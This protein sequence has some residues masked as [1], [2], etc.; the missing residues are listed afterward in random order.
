MAIDVA[1]AQRTTANGEWSQRVG[2]YTH[3]PALICQLG[4]D[5][6]AT[7]ARVGLTRTALADSD[8][9]I[10]YVSIVALLEAA[11]KDTGCA[12][13][14]L[15]AGRMWHLADLGIV[16]ELVA[17]ARNVGEALEMLTVHQQLNSRGGLAFMLQRAGMVDLGYA[18]YHPGIGRSDQMYDATLAFGMNMMRELCGAGWTPSEVFLPHAKPDEAAHYRSVFKIGA[19][20][21]AEICALRFPESW[22]GQSVAGFDPA[23]ARA[24]RARAHRAPAVGLVENV[25]R[26]LRLVMVHGSTSGDAVAQMLSMHRRTLNRRLK[27]EGVTFQQILDDVR[28]AVARELLGASRLSL[29]DVAAALGYAGVSPF[30]RAFHRWTGN[31]AGEWRRAARRGEFTQV[32][33]PRLLPRL[34]GLTGAS[35]R[36]TP[37]R[38]KKR[39]VFS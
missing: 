18:V 9:R 33:P 29:D 3:V 1:S 7:L 6:D 15:L 21:D 22:L 32:S 17:S 37:V 4:G 27:E 5:A 20:F 25:Y 16:G 23:R 19:R 28:F 38:C 13:F 10:P 39:E 14:G 34:P 30:M 26:A 24:A 12:H 36:G 35:L 11:A 31:T 2:A 8:S